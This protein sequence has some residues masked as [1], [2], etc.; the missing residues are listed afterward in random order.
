VGSLPP[1]LGLADTPS[2]EEAADWVRRTISGAERHRRVSFADIVRAA[3]TPSR[4]RPGNGP[5]TPSEAVRSAEETCSRARSDSVQ[6]TEQAAR[7]RS[8]LFDRPTVEALGSRFTRLLSAVAADA[9]VPV[10]AIELAEG[11]E[12]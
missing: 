6:Q 12:C 10:H 9:N 3:G 1:R 4:N 5:C 7:T 8:D 11:R 2:F